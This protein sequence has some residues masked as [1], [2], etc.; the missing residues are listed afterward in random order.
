VKLTIWRI[1]VESSTI[2]AVLSKTHLLPSR[3][4]LMPGNRLMPAK[5]PGG[6]ERCSGKARPFF[7]GT[8]SH[9]N[10]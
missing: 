2:S 1:D 7:R 5:M 3:T 4:F 9:A 10:P 8:A 6:A